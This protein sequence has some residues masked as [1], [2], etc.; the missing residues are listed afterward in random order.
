MK[1]TILLIFVCLF[2][3]Q[4]NAWKSTRRIKFTNKCQ[5]TLWI[6]AFAV[7]LPAQTGWE[8]SPNSEKYISV[9]SNTVAARFWARTDCKWTNGK[10]ICLTGDCGAFSN[11]FG[12]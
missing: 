4:V 9:P 2:S 10:F 12:V 11:N 6:G 1:I 8:M 3:L 7:P 5:Q